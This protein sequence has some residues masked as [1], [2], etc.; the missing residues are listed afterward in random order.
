MNIGPHSQKLRPEIRC[1][2]FSW[3]RWR[4][5]ESKRRRFRHW[6][7]FGV[8]SSS[9]SGIAGSNVPRRSVDEMDP[10]ES[11]HCH[12]PVTDRSHRPRRHLHSPYSRARHTSLPSPAGQPVGRTRCI[13]EP[14]EK[15]PPKTFLLGGWS[16][17]CARGLGISVL[18]ASDP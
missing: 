17:A 10:A 13:K 3:A 1:L 14:S 2:V 5:K 18:V 15:W 4:T 16:I 12:R 9:S 8:S 11:D 6:R 7:L